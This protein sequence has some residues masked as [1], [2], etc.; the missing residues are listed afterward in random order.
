MLKAVNFQDDI[1][2]L[3]CDNIYRSGD[4]PSILLYHDDKTTF[5]MSFEFI[6]HMYSLVKFLSVMEDGDY[7]E[8]ITFEQWT[9]KMF[10]LKNSEMGKLRKKL[11]DN[12]L[13]KLEVKEVK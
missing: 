4:N 2:Y 9:K 1:Y 10:E 3:F 6:E 8:L 7:N 5:K 11:A 13:Y 12:D